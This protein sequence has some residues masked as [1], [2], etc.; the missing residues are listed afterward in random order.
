[1]IVKKHVLLLFLVGCCSL[2]AF[3][4]PEYAAIDQQSLLKHYT[5]FKKRAAVLSHVIKEVDAGLQYWQREKYIEYRTPWYRKSLY[6]SFDQ[7]KYYL[8]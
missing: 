7:K 4:E 2:E 6:R 1:M 8:D 3:V 5:F